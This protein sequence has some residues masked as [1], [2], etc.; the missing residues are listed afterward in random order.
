MSVKSL[1]GSVPS[2]FT[3]GTLFGK[4]GE[5]AE[6]TAAMALFK[7][8]GRNAEPVDE[9]SFSSQALAALKSGAGTAASRPAPTLAAS[10]AAAFKTTS[11]APASAPRG[12]SQTAASRPRTDDAGHGAPAPPDRSPPR[13]DVEGDRP[14]FDP[15]RDAREV[16]R[17]RS[18]TIH[19][20]AR[21]EM[22]RTAFGLPK[23]VEA[24]GG[25]ML[26]GHIESVID[27]TMQLDAGTMPERPMSEPE[28]NTSMITLLLP[29]SR[30][31]LNERIEILFDDT[32][33]SKLAAMSPDAVKAGL[34]D[35]MADTDTAR[36]GTAAM[37]SGS[38]GQF[39]AENGDR[40]P[41]YASP[42][43][44]Y[45]LFDPEQGESGQPMLMIQSR[46]R[47][48]YVR[49]HADDLVDAVMGLLRGLAPSGGG[50]AASTGATTTA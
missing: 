3:T 48:D 12:A 4:A 37:T 50:A 27:R 34:V 35:M 9:V 23:E 17:V 11:A 41:E 43:A 2:L 46:S 10:E 15:S 47:P 18:G 33:M 19:G 42:K 8:V 20:F 45:G 28:A 49:E 44:R 14:V 30:S 22:L 39:I 31:G 13:L 24:G 29:N 26:T 38:L 21:N 36:A 6:T 40:H 16:S 5:S 32:T 1:S 7:P 25:L